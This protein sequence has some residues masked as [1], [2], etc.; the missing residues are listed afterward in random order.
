MP[1]THTI[2]LSCMPCCKKNKPCCGAGDTL[3]ATIAS[4]CPGL[5]G[6]VVELN[7]VGTYVWSGFAAGAGGQVDVHLECNGGKPGEW[8][9][10]ISCNASPSIGTFGVAP[11]SCSPLEVVFELTAPAG[12]WEGSGCTCNFQGGERVIVTITL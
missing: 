2:D 6:L 8:A 11:V 3:Y 7:K 10:S 9:I 12:V 1:Q 4:D 5:D